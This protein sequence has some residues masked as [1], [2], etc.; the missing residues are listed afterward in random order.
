MESGVPVGAGA[1]WAPWRHGSVVRFSPLLQECERAR[2]SA[3]VRVAGRGV[4]AQLR[5]VSD[6]TSLSGGGTAW[7]SESDCRRSRGLLGC[8][9][10]RVFHLESTM[11]LIL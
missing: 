1:D 9:L 5:E 6:R 7:L 11:L 10:A 2:A 8:L 4:T 3:V